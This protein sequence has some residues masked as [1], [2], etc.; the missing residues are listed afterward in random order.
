MILID[1]TTL[2]K[3]KLQITKEEEEE[4]IILYDPIQHSDLWSCVTI[5]GIMY[6]NDPL[7]VDW[8]EDVN[9][10]HSVSMG[11]WPFGAPFLE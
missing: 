10:W 8:D 7:L 1:E 6:T 3:Y 5:N 11:A 4:G 2:L 9:E